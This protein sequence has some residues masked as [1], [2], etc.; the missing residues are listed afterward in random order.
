MDISSVGEFGLIRKIRKL[1]PAASGV[2]KGI[3]DDTAV[4][5]YTKD[6]YQ[7]FT[8]DMLVEGVHYVLAVTWYEDNPLRKINIRIAV[9]WRN[10]T[11]RRRCTLNYEI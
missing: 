8:T 7:L 4:L 9:C 1:A 3:G 5:K 10:K 11:K 6:K 2:V